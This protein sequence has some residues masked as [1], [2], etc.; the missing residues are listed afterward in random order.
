MIWHPNGRTNSGLLNEAWNDA[1]GQQ[2]IE[3]GMEPFVVYPPSK[4]FCHPDQTGKS[5]YYDAGKF[6]CSDTKEPLM[7]IVELE[8][9]PLNIVRDPTAFFDNGDAE[10]SDYDVYYLYNGNHS[11]SF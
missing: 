7:S 9:Y 10:R 1:R 5:F 11:S 3:H 2:I 8:G 4:C 6:F